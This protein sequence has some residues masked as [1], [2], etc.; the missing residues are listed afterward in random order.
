MLGKSTAYLAKFENGDFSIPAEILLDAIEVCGST[1]EEFFYH[2]F[3]K[4]NEHKELIST[5]D[6]L[7]GESKETIKNIIK[8]MK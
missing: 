1:P 5:F 4:Y 3:A 6:K 7:S 2:D 8:N